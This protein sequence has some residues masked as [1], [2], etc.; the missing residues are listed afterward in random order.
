VKTVLEKLGDNP[1][2]YLDLLVDTDP[3][4]LRDLAQQMYAELKALRTDVWLANAMVCRD[5]NDDNGLPIGGQI[6]SAIRPY[7][8]RVTEEWGIY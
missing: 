3:L 6:T 4:K 5:A 1:W 2:D 8:D 7:L